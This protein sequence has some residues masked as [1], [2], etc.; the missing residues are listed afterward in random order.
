MHATVW[1]YDCFTSFM[2][3]ALQVVY[4]LNITEHVG[5]AA[6]VAICLEPLLEPHLGHALVSLSPISMIIEL[7]GMTQLIFVMA[8]RQFVDYSQSVSTVVVL[9]L[10][11]QQKTIQRSCAKQC[12][13]SREKDGNGR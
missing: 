7:L 6:D 3:A 1:S 4:T 12:K 8:L 9:M 2:R 5:Q 13:R 10:R 11:E